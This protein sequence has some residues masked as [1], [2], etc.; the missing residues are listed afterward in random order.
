[1]PIWVI[2]MM[3]RQQFSCRSPG[4]GQS[5]ADDV[6]GGHFDRRGAV[7]RGERCG[8]AEPVDGPDP[9][10]N[11]AGQLAADAVE[12]GQCAPASV[13]AAA[14]SDSPFEVRRSTAICTAEWKERP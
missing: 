12:L 4:P 5:V 8:R 9:G 2:A 1:V 14:T 3:C 10:E 13:T 6:A 11:L 7:E